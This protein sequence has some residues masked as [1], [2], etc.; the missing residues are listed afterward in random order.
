MMP[1]ICVSDIDKFN[2]KIIF[3]RISIVKDM[4]EYSKHAVQTLNL[5]RTGDSPIML[6]SAQ[7][8]DK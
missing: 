6:T 3:H 2:I 4:T 5:I 1:L 7:E 8:R